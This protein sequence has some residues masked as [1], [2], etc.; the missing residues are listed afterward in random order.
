MAFVIIDHFL[1][2]L[3]LISTVWH[4]PYAM[5][6]S[7]NSNQ[8][9]KNS[10]QAA[11]NQLPCYSGSHSGSPWDFLDWI[12]FA[13]EIADA[14]SRIDYSSCPLAPGS[15][16]AA[17]AAVATACCLTSHLLPLYYPSSGCSRWRFHFFKFIIQYHLWVF[18]LLLPNPIL[19]H[20]SCLFSYYS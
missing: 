4:F 16:A 9:C 5:H 8:S 7:S 17:P 14:D 18:L 12:N 11:Q 10:S 3:Y 2:F 6:L 15:A 19:L 20:Y 1:F 13:K